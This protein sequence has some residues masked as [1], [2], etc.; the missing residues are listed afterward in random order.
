MVW[1]RIFKDV[2]DKGFR[3]EYIGEVLYV[4]M[5]DEFELVVDKCEII[6]IIDVEKV[7]ELKGEVI[8]KYNVRDERLVLLVDE[9][10]DIFYFCNLC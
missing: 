2:F 3:F 10:V 1:V 4:K 6:I 9:S 5:L 7:F 8:V